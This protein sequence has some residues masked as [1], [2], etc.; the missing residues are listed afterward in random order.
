MI[1]IIIGALLLK[2]STLLT[3][4]PKVETLLHRTPMLST[5]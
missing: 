1:P 2:T 3:L 5:L 4:E